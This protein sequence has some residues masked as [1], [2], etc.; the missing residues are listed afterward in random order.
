MA[1][2]IGVGLQVFVLGQEEADL[3]VRKTMCEVVEGKMH[4]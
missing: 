3:M 4:A 2:E 1:M